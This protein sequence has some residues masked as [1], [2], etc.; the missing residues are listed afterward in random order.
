M[1]SIP[2][3]DPNKLTIHDGDAFTN[4]FNRLNQDPAKPLLNRATQD[5]YPVGSTFKVI[6]SAA[7]LSSGQ[8]TPQTQI[9]AGPSYQPVPGPGNFT[10]HNAVAGICPGDQISL[11]DA[12]TQSCN[13]GFAHLGVTLGADKVK[14]MAQAFGYEEG[15]LTL[16]GKGQSAIGLVASHTGNMT[17]DNGHDDPNKV[18][19]SSIGQLEV[20]AT[21]LL[22]AMVAGAV[23][24]GGDEMRPYLVDKHQAPDLSTTDQTSPTAWR[25]P[26]TKD[27]ADQLQQMMISVV[28]HGTGTNAKINGVQV[29]GK[30]GT[31][32]NGEAAGD[33]GWFIG[34]AI[35]DGHPI[36]AVAVFLQNAGSGGSSEATRIAGDVMRTVLAER[37]QK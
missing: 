25:H 36:C 37:G 29:G 6:V 16:A 30:T 5:V 13:T 3:Y 17:G 23:A 20:K 31:A 18:A 32:Q 33:H 9:P 19:Q 24:N 4:E 22:A 2:S 34:F 10:I 26:I 15:G 27:V 7:A 35:K 21:P 8:Y 14:A 28:D 11:I 1:A 12:L